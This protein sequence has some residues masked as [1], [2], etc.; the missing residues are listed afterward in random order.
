MKLILGDRSY[1]IEF[2]PDGVIV[3]GEPFRV[4]VEGIG[5]TRVATVNGRPIR[6]DV[7][8]AENG[9]SSVNVEGQTFLAR[10]EGSDRPRPPRPAAT[11]SAVAPGASARA[12]VKGAITAQ[13]TG[14]IVRVAV[15]P[16]DVVAAGDLLLILEAMKMENE[17]RAPR[18]GTVK[19]VRVAAG[20]RVGQGDPLVVL[21]DG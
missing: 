16:G 14:R 13:M 17:V 20:D 19:E 3:D 12:A 8:P 4:T 5:G 9:A 10:L 6:V 21:A 18:D 2:T 7:E 15:A 11:A 1:T